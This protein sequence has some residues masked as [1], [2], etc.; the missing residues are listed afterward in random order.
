MGVKNLGVKRKQLPEEHSNW[1]F[2]QAKDPY[3]HLSVTVNI[4]SLIQGLHGH[5]LVAQKVNCFFL[6]FLSVLRL[7]ILIENNDSTQ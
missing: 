2:G 4:Y 7:P 6:F 3:Y 5:Y 1:K